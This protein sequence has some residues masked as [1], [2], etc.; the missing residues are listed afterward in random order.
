MFIPGIDGGSR[1]MAAPA[2]RTMLLMPP[3]KHNGTDSVA[4]YDAPLNGD[5]RNARARG[6]APLLWRLTSQQ[7]ETGYADAMWWVLL[8]M[9]AAWWRHPELRKSVLLARLN[10]GHFSD[11]Q[12]HPRAKKVTS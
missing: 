9:I 2:Y 5:A 11:V 12:I 1:N 8:T 4:R 6:P 7:G 3:S 10:V